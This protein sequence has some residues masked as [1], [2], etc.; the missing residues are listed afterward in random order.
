M[1]RCFVSMKTV[2]TLRWLP[3]DNPATPDQVAKT[4]TSTR[5]SD[6]AFQPS[7][8]HERLPKHLQNELSNRWLS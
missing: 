2:E 3:A 6:L 8:L 4:A 1:T 5:C 7:Q